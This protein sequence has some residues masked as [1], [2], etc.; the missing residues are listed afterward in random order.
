M[1]WALAAAL[2]LLSGCQKS[3]DER[4]SEAQ[5]QIGEQAMSI[6]K[7]LAAKASE[8]AVGEA[9]ASEAAAPAASDAGT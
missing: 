5:K 4:Y 9:L 6:D 3:F 2:L 1:R 8:A 7:D